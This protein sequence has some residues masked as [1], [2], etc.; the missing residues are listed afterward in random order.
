VD[1]VSEKVYGGLAAGAVPIYLGA[2][3]IYD[4]TFVPENS[5]LIPPNDVT[6]AAAMQKF[7]AEVPRTIRPCTLSPDGMA[8][9][10]CD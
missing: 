4:S 6:N 1:Y 9:E 2:P 8:G 5:L 10:E 3:N 7:A